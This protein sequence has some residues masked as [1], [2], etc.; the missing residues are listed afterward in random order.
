[1]RNVSLEEKWK[2]KNEKQK[3]Y[4]HNQMAWDDRGEL[5]NEL[6][7]AIDKLSICNSF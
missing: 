5:K 1:M 7:G 6:N 3:R 4:R 2:K